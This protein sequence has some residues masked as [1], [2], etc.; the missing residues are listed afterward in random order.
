MN[1]WESFFTSLK[2]VFNSK[3]GTDMSED[4]SPTDALDIINA[5]E[6]DAVSAEN[7]QSIEQLVARMDSHDEDMRLLGDNLGTLTEQFGTLEGQQITEAQLEQINTNITG[8][9]DEVNKVKMSYTNSGKVIQQANKA[10]EET[11]PVVQ[12]DGMSVSLSLA[13]ILTGQIK[14]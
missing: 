2:S 7:T 6:S 12:K 14:N 9:E 8:L 13:E 1:K 3:F 10:A 11:K 5:M 4:T